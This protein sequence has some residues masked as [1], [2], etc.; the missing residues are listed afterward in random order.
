VLREDGCLLAPRDRSIRGAYS[1][2]HHRSSPC[3]WRQ[4][5][6]LKRWSVSTRLHGATSQKTAIFILVAVRTSYHNYLRKSYFIYP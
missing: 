6:L 2:Y 4:Y 3:L 5:D 1:F